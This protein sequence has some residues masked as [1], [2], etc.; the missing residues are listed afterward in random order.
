L[1]DLDRTIKAIAAARALFIS[2][3]TGVPVS[4]AKARWI[5][6][7]YRRL[8]SCLF[9]RSLASFLLAR[10]GHM[11]EFAA[12]TRVAMSEEERMRKEGEA[13]YAAHIR[14]WG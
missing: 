12:K 1:E 7:Q 10:M 4:D 3:E 14:G 5:L 13:F 6:G 11:G 2:R 9:V 8:L